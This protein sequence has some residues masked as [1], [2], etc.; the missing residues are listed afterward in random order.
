MKK[1]SKSTT[2]KKAKELALIFSSFL[3]GNS[4]IMDSKEIE[5]ILKVQKQISELAIINDPEEVTVLLR[6][7]TR[8]IPVSMQPLLFATV[9]KVLT[10]LKHCSV[11]DLYSTLID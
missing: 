7:I 8:D 11:E 3:F 4:P 1:D 2:A 5:E 6:N 9:A 10:E